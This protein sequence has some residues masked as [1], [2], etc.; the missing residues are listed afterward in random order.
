MKHPVHVCILSV[1]L[2]LLCA[3]LLTNKWVYNTR[4]YT[5]YIC[6][7]KAKHFTSA[8][9]TRNNCNNEDTKHSSAKQTFTADAV[10]Q[11]FVRIQKKA[12]NTCPMVTGMSHACTNAHNEATNVSGFQR[13]YTARHTL[14]TVLYHSTRLSRMLAVTCVQDRETSDTFRLQAATVAMHLPTLFDCK[15]HITSDA[16]HEEWVSVQSLPW[17]SSHNTSFWRHVFRGNWLHT[18][19]KI[20]TRKYA[21]LN[22]NTNK[23]HL[24]TKN[25][26]K[27]TKIET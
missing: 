7:N 26:E 14:T 21:N 8:S 16:A 11:I 5:L 24:V 9:L 23:R 15:K 17:Y 12:V 18:K 1:H 10:Q 25:V 6:K 3:A 27:R 19:L 20:T 2:C 4:V 22:T 13:S